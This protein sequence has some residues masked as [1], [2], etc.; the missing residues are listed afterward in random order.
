[1]DRQ[2]RAER[3]RVG[4]R[5]QA[6]LEARGGL[7]DDVQLGDGPALVITQE[8][9]RGAE[10]R[11]ERGG[12]LGR[13]GADNREVAVVDGQLVLQRR[14]VPDLARALWSPVAAV[15]AQ[16]ERKAVGELGEPDRLAPVVRELQI[17]KA[18]ADDQIRSH[19]TSPQSERPVQQPL[20][21]SISRPGQAK[22]AKRA[23]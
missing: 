11:A 20:A 5:D 4:Q 9:E 7:L 6:V 14:E 23:R 16:D 15:E 13:I 18:T 10:A 19:V 12:D 8:R 1:V 2:I 22:V 17:G 3:E 21:P